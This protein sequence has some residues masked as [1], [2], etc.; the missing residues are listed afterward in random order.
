L[1]HARERSPEAVLKPVAASRLAAAED[2]MQALQPGVAQP[3]DAVARRGKEGG[4]ATASRAACLRRKVFSL[5]S[6]PSPHRTLQ[7]HRLRTLPAPPQPLPEHLQWARRLEAGRQRR[8]GQPV[9]LSR[10]GA[11]LFQHRPASRQQ[12]QTRSPVS[13]SMA[14][15]QPKDRRHS[16]VAGGPPD[17]HRSSSSG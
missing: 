16:N 17:R 12:A 9:G 13:A 14:H 2:A 5:P 11:Q 7:Q 10:A 1:P 15:A 4:G 6:R 3:A 8:T